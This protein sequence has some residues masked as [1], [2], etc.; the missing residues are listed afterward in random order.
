MCTLHDDD[1]DDDDDVNDLNDDD[2]DDD[3]DDMSTTSTQCQPPNIG[4]R[5]GPLISFCFFSKTFEF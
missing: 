4:H 3:D 1:D 2:D 5:S